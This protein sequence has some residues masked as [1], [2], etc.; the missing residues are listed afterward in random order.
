MKERKKIILFQLSFVVIACVIIEFVLRGMGYPPGDLRPNWLWF[1]PVDSLYI[2]HD[3]YTNDKGLLVADKD[4]WAKEKIA[5]NSEGFRGKEFSE[6]DSTK[7]KVL[8]IGDSFTW[9]MSASPFQDS[10]YCDLLARETNY[11]IVNTGIPAADP[12]QYLKVVEEY[13]PIVKPNII[14]VM[15]FMG[16]DLMKEDRQ[17]I[18]NRPFYYW[19]N[20]GAVLADIDGKHYDNPQDAYN[21]LSNEKYFLKHP[22]KWYEVVISKSALLSR[23]YAARFRIEEKLDYERR[24]QDTSLTKKYL[25]GIIKAAA[26]NS[27]EVRFILIPEKKEADISR[28]KYSE[29]YSNLLKDEEL[30]NYWVAWPTSDALFRPNPDGHLNNEGH[31]LYADS[32]KSLLNSYFNAR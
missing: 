2:I 5:I 10:S 25:A 28:E 21:Y 8:F 27:T 4:Y 23:L 20:A 12:P 22:T 14:L 29:R 1:N 17:V 30:K 6:L 13:T 24:R 9:G 7:K 19:T 11:E 32:I 3:Y 18:P 31:R 16:N 15:F 26:Q